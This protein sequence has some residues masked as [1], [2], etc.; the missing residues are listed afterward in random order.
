MKLSLRQASGFVTD[1]FVD[2][3]MA[4]ADAAVVA[5]VLLWA[6]AR[7]T[8]THGLSRIPNY[9]HMID[10]GDTDPR[11]AP[12]IRADMGAILAMDGQ[13]AA[14]PVAMMRAL[15]EVQAR[16][17]QFGIGLAV[18]GETTHTG[19]IGCYAE[20]AARAGFAAIVM[21]AGPPIMAYE[22]AAV[23]SV[24]TAPLALAAPGGPDGVVLLDMASSLVSN[25]RLKQAQR[26]HETIPESWALTADGR[27]TTDA[28]EAMIPLPM[29]GAKG[30]GLSLMIECL[31]S[32]LAA[33]P[34]LSAALCPGGRK[35]HVQNAT[36]ILIDVAAFRALSDYAQDVDML[37]AII[38]ALP[39]LEGAEPIRLP[40]ERGGRQAARTADDGL[41]IDPKT[42]RQLAEIA[43]VRGLTA[44]AG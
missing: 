22:G 31:T 1:L 25:G 26:Q 37:A 10:R 23:A 29:A 32:L 43:A 21:A 2:R 34:I 18:V 13:H 42:W 14:G 39:R 44:P 5:D 27:R 41:R 17:R 12:R 40:G 28:T 36:I 19:A 11:A 7:G 4:A 38:H 35:R 30:A 6:E 3:G 33:A 20:R 24:S 15:A 8:D 9:L 16:A